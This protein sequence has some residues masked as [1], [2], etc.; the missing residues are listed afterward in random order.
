MPLALYNGTHTYSLNIMNTYIYIYGEIQHTFK[1]SYMVS[2]L[3]Q[4]QWIISCA[5]FL[6]LI[7]FTVYLLVQYT[8]SDEQL[9]QVSCSPHCW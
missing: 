3:A 7:L 5:R 1:H 9:L 2:I 4:I 6:V 8:S